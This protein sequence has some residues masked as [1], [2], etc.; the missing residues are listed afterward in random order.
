MKIDEKIHA[1]RA[2]ADLLDITRLNPLQP[3]NTV[4]IPVV[5]DQHGACLRRLCRRETVG[6]VE[7]GA[8][9]QL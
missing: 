7:G 8:G 5:T 9:N 6:Q 4:E 2:A 3:L 1:G